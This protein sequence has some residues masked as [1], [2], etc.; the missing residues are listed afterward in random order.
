MTQPD[1]SAARDP[2]RSLPAPP[3]P[4]AG[5]GRPGRDGAD[6]RWARFRALTRGR[7]QPRHLKR[8]RAC[9]L[10][11][12]G[13]RYGRRQL[14]ARHCLGLRTPPGPGPCPPHA[15]RRG[16]AAPAAL[17]GGGAAPPAGPEARGTGTGGEGAPGRR[18]PFDGSRRMEGGRQH[19]ASQEVVPV[20]GSLSQWRR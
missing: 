20:L 1:T 7:G 15:D 17:P 16:T 11:T 4:A 8:C 3:A 14:G 2:A 12:T 18:G 19:S 9:A 6:S 13:A 5:A 10:L